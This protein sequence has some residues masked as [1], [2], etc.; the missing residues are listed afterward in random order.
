[1]DEYLK[2]H[3]TGRVR[4]SVEVC[5]SEWMSRM[6]CEWVGDEMRYGPSDFVADEIQMLAAARVLNLRREVW[7]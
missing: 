4:G 5:V 6:S 3:V 7:K 2:G 1:M